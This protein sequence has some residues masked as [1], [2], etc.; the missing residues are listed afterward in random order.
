MLKSPDTVTEAKI[1]RKRRAINVMVRD[2]GKMDQSDK[3][4]KSRRKKTLWK[5]LKLLEGLNTK[6]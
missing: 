2:E 1:R 5:I 4:G 6:S 3:E